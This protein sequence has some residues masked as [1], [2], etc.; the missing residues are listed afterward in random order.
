ML[1]GESYLDFCSRVILNYKDYGFADINEVVPHLT[2]VDM[3]DNNRRC[4][5]NN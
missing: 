3:K 4:R 2:N 5:E 1:D